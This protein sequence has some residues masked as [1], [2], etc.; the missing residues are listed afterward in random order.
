[1]NNDGDYHIPRVVGKVL[2]IILL[3]HAVMPVH[4]HIFND[5]PKPFHARNQRQKRKVARQGQ[6]KPR[7]R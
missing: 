3:A 4:K 6:K 7:R 2:S 1:M 5:K